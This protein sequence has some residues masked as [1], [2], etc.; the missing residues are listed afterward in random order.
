[1]TDVRP[2]AIGL[3]DQYATQVAADLERNASEQRRINAEIAV[4]QEH[5]QTLQHDQAL[6]EGVQQ[7]LDR[8]TSADPAP[9]RPAA[10]V[11][12]QAAVGPGTVKPAVG[13]TSAK[14]KPSAVKSPRGKAAAAGG[15]TVGDLIRAYLVAQPEPRSAAEIT[16]A[17]ADAHPERTVKATVVRAAVENLVA[18][19][20]AER[21]KQ[22]S[23][24][25]YSTSTPRAALDG[26]QPEPA[27]DATST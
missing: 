26:N 4:L 19:S 9:R 7:A 16:E 13:G 21:T 24:V 11:P 18:K 8:A 23:S 20:L 25:F 17:L 3:K 1:M 15:L 5:L 2:E 6:L 22:G 10:S 27:P 14:R 12:R